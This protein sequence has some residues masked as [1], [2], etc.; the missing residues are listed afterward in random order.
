VSASTWSAFLQLMLHHT[1]FND[2]LELTPAGAVDDMLCDERFDTVVL[3]FIE[4]LL[5][6]SLEDCDMEGLVAG[7]LLARQACLEGAH[8]FMSYSDWFQ[9]ERL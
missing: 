2:C 9:V 6:Q 4:E 8:V 3:D 7:I 5:R 1:T